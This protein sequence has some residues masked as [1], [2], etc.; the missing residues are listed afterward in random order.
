MK[1]R[2]I[3]LILLLFGLTA[4]NNNTKNIQ[5]DNSNEIKTK[6]SCYNEG[7]LFHSKKSV[8]HIMYLDK[9]NKLVQY[10]HIEKYFDFDDDND[11]NMICEGSAE[12]EVNNNK[13]YPYLKEK[14]NCNK[15][16][17]EVTIS[18][19]YY[20]NKLDS[21]N[22]LRSDEL[23]DSLDDNYLLDID[24]YKTSISKKGYTCK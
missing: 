21:K 12:E 3:I 1:Y 19:L 7:Y 24:K 11:F 14:A 9:D 6:L 20:I 15:E 8:E 2:N 4:C 5:I 10:E 23:I 18:D 22:K 17:K 16:I 13:L